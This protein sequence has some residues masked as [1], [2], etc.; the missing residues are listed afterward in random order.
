MPGR[1]RGNQ[2][3]QSSHYGAPRALPLVAFFRLPFPRLHQGTLCRTDR[4]DLSRQEEDA[5]LS[6]ASEVLYA[7]DVTVVHARRLRQFDADPLSSCEVDLADVAHSAAHPLPGNLVAQREAAVDRLPS[8]DLQ[9]PAPPCLHGLVV[10]AA[11]Y[12]LPGQQEYAPLGCTLEVLN[13]HDVAVMHAFGIRHLY[14]HPLACSELDLTD[15]AHDTA[16]PLPSDF[17]PQ[18]KLAVGCLLF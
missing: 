18:P 2:R 5:R 14:A 16:I 10:E 12:D 8:S 1:Q 3:Q 6:R 4:L 11:G 13:A 17:A 7:V 15:V 9:V